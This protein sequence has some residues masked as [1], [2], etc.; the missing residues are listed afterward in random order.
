MTCEGSHPTIMI[1]FII[2]I[3]FWVTLLTLQQPHSLLTFDLEQPEQKQSW[4]GRHFCY[5]QSLFATHFLQMS[6]TAHISPYVNSVVTA[7]CT[8]LPNMHIKTLNAR[9]L[10]KRL[11]D[12]FVICSQNVMHSDRS[13]IKCHLLVHYLL[14][15]PTLKLICSD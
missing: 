1:Y 8:V 11:A 12:V 3:L 2:C 15:I 13:L 9:S 14:H 7:A 5:N 6:G 4:Q 10:L